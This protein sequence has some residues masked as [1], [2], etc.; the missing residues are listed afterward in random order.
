MLAKFL[1]TVLAR[2][3]QQHTAREGM[4]NDS[5]EPFLAGFAVLRFCA[6]TAE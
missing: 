1:A 2:F 5:Q 6:E 3:R 4:K